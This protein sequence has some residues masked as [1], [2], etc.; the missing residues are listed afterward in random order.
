M[1]KIHQPITITKR[2]EWDMGHRIRGHHKDQHLHGHR[3]ALE[4]TMVSKQFHDIG[5]LAQTLRKAIGDS[6]DHSFVF[7]QKD[8]IMNEFF[9]LNRELKHLKLP[10]EP[11]MENMLV[12]VS[13][14]LEK[15]KIFQ[16][17][18]SL[19]KLTLWESKTNSATLEF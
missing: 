8:Q 10:K 15:Q 17:E 9:A 6:L 13:E 14:K 5:L 1:K 11:T 2:I 7:C 3:Y 16:K 19:K 4:V 12:W 18:V